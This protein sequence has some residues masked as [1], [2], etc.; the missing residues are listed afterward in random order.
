M[1]WMT[2]KGSRAAA[3]AILAILAACC[4]ALAAMLLPGCIGAFSRVATNLASKTANSASIAAVAS[5]LAVAVA[6]AVFSVPMALAL[7]CLPGKWARL[8]QS[9]LLF[10][11]LTVICAIIMRQAA[12]VAGVPSLLVF[13][14]C[15][16]ALLLPWAAARLARTMRRID[17]VA[18]RAAASLGVSRRRTLWRIVLPVLRPC[19]R[20]NLNEALA[21]GAGG[22]LLHGVDPA[23]FP[24]DIASAA[25]LVGAVLSAISL[26]L[27]QRGVNEVGGGEV[28]DGAADRLEQGDLVR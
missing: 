27:P 6:C 25:A 5:G 21:V 14:G 13:L 26:L 23:P 20:L 8:A 11:A 22:F 2:G 18:L 3:F 7:V 10:P 24:H 16:V 28:L 19:L 1:E 9:L 15:L 12:G 17:P 4:L